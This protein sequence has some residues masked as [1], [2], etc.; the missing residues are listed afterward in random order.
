MRRDALSQ[1]G[2]RFEFGLRL[3]FIKIR[4]DHKLI[5]N[6]FVRHIS[7]QGRDDQALPRDSGFETC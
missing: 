4:L 1:V 6:V 3:E 2:E 5:G 7:R